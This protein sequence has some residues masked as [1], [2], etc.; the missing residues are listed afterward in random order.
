MLS[1]NKPKMDKAFKELCKKGSAENPDSGGAIYKA[2]YHAYYDKTKEKLPTADPEDSDLKNVLIEKSA[3]TNH[4]DKQLKDDSHEFASLFADA[5]DEILI[6][7][8][9]QIDAHIKSIDFTLVEPVPNITS[10]TALVTAAGPAT[11]SIS[12][13][14]TTGSKLTI[15]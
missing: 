11:G 5:M 6:E 13:N 8:S 2:A 12:I 4:I 7:V 1:T 10:G 15:M 14:T 9:T 3:T